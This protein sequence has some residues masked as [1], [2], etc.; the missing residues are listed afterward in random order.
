MKILWTSKATVLG[1][2]GPAGMSRL[3]DVGFLCSLKQLEV[4]LV[5]TCASSSRLFLM[6]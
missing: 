4:K 5:N 2:D 3:R 1:E 6:A